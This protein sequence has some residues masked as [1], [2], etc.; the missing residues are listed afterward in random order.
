LHDWIEEIELPEGFE[1]KV[2]VISR[3]LIHVARNLAINNAIV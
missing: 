3:K 1:V 2:E